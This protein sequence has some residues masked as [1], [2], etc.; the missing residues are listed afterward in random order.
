V[1]NRELIKKTAQKYKTTEINIV[2]EYIQHLFLSFFYREKKSEHVLFKGGTALR[3]IFQSPRFSEDLDFSGYRI[4]FNMLETLLVNVVEK[5]SKT[6]VEIEISESKS[7]SG[8]YIGVIDLSC[9]GYKTRILMEVSLRRQNKVKGD[10]VLVAGD[11]LP[12]Y[13]VIMLPQKNLIEEKLEAVLTR[14]KPRDYYDLYFL[15][16][17]GLIS[18]EQRAL[19]NKIKSHL[20][21]ERISVEKELRDFLPEDQQK[22]IR[23]FPDILLKEIS[24]YVW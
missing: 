1:I 21:K 18:V 22:I 15:L 24:R 23:H 16:R 20:M 19:L 14:A 6:G 11:F 13:T 17:K 12:P 2:R 10:I 8:G 3:I 7:T 4:T 5:I 9:S